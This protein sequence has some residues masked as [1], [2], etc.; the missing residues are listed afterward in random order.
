MTEVAF[1]VNAP[2]KLAYA[3]RLLRKAWRS[4]ARVA[5]VGPTPVLH[6][7]DD[8][9]W[10]FSA[11][12]FIPHCLGTADESVIRASAIV[13]VDDARSAP[14][15][16]VLVNLGEAVAPGFERFDRVIELADAGSDD[17]RAARVR[18][19]HYASRGYVLTH[20]DAAAGSNAAH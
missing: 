17:V 14:H 1:H 12:D 10:T 3:C 4:G 18:W 16:Q 15:Q 20:L 19:K 13:L 9:L 6:Q 7:L 11:H 8:A 5:V 2:D